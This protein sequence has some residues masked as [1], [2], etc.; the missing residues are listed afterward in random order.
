M[1]IINNTKT[2]L[3]YCLRRIRDLFDCVYCIIT[4]YNF[5]CAHYIWIYDVLCI[6][7]YPQKLIFIIC[8]GHT[9]GVRDTH[10]SFW[11]FPDGVFL[12]FFFLLFV[13]RTAIFSAHTRKGEYGILSVSGAALGLS[14][15]IR[16]RILT[17]F[18]RLFDFLCTDPPGITCLNDHNSALRNILKITQWVSSSVG[19]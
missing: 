16:P 15:N 5:L 9:K 7:I 17:A 11:L 1:I 2:C 12:V 3:W 14:T 18:G 4:S 13:I 19:I 10:A 6:H 8:R